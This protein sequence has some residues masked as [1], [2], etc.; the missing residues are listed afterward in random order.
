MIWIHLI[1]NIDVLIY[2]QTITFKKHCEMKSIAFDL[3]PIEYDSFEN[4]N[5][6]KKK[7]PG[8]VNFSFKC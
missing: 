5:I 3:S 4:D 1:D 7:N 8:K 2:D 6:Q